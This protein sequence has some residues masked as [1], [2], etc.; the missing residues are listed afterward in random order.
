MYLIWVEHVICNS[1]ST[2]FIRNF[3]ITPSMSLF[4]NSDVVTIVE[5]TVAKVNDGF[6][7]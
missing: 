5:S 2:L 3:E 4:L 6:Q 7:F 1:R